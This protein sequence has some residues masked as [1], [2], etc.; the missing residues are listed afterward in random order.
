MASVLIE[1][2]DTTGKVTRRLL[3]TRLFADSNPQ[4]GT[5]ES[6]RKR[7]MRR[8]INGLLSCGAVVETAYGN[9][10]DPAKYAEW[11]MRPRRHGKLPL[12]PSRCNSEERA[13]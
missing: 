11:V 13:A 3:R 1:T 6:I 7:V 12:H 10:I 5:Y 2:D 4:H 9:F 8:H